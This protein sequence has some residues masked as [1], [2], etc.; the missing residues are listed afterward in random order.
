M[1]VDQ[2]HLT[3]I[4]H[5]LRNP[6][7]GAYGFVQL[8]QEAVQRLEDQWPSSPDLLPTDLSLL[9]TFLAYAQTEQ[10]QANRLLTDFTTTT[11]GGGFS[12]SLKE[13][14]VIPLLLDH[15]RRRQALESGHRIEVQGHAWTTAPPFWAHLDADRVGQVLTNYIENA[16]AYAPLSTPVTISLRVRRRR[17]RILVHDRG[18]GIA[19]S[20]LPRIWVAGY[21]AKAAQELRPNGSGQ[22]LALVRSI[23]ELHGGCVGVESREGKGSTFWFELPI[24]RKETSHG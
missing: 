2:D 14:E 22:G 24:Q 16:L 4:R 20:A 13:Q 23:V 7:T 3:L 12:L 1:S 18:K 19:S 17:I 21:R 6:L 5:E 8:A 9:K 10:E 15:I 11:Q